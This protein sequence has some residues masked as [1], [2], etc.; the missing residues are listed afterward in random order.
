MYLIMLKLFLKMLRLYLYTLIIGHK[1]CSMLSIRNKST[2]RKELANF[3]VNNN[4]WEKQNKNIT[5]KQK[6]KNTCRSRELNPGP[7]ALQSGV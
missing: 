6:S 5:T 2:L 1:F 3:H 7:L 4:F